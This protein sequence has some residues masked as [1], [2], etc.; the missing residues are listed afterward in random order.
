[1]AVAAEHEAGD[2]RLHHQGVEPGGV[3]ARP[4]SSRSRWSR[5][6]GRSSPRVQRQERAGCGGVALGADVARARPTPS[7]RPAVNE[8]TAV[9]P[10]LQ[11][12]TGITSDA[13]C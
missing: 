11:V 9:L 5:R 10:G 7:D 6:R 3:A 8:V 1:M 12:E 2:E 13:G 4:W